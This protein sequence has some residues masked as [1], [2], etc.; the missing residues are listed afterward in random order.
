MT[1]FKGAYH[2]PDMKNPEFTVHFNED[3]TL[4]FDFQDTIND[5][6]YDPSKPGTLNEVQLKALEQ[7]KKANKA[8]NW[9]IKL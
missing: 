2:Y 4:N 9:N 8:N 1:S 3:G 6:Q 5:F 7:L